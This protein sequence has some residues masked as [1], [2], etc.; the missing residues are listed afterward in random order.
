M[1][2]ELVGGRVLAPFVGTSIFVWS[3]LIGVILAA[4]SAGY[5]WGGRWADKYPDYKNFSQVIFMAAALIA[6]TGIFK[7]PIMNYL[8]RMNTDISLESIFATLIL[9]A[10]ASFFLATISPYAARLRMEDIKQSGQIVGNLY[11]IS[12][13]GSILGTFLTGF[14]L[15]SYVGSTKIIFILAILMFLA[16]L[17][18]FFDNKNF[19]HFYWILFLLIFIFFLTSWWD[20]KYRPTGQIYIT[21][22][23]SDVMLTKGIDYFTLRPI[24]ALITDP[25]GIQSAMYLDKDTGPVAK[26]LELFRLV[27]YFKPDFKKTLMLGGAGYS[28]PKD[29]LKRYQ[30]ATI[31]VV[32]IDPKMTA[33]ARQYFNLKDDSRL[34]I[35]HEDGRVYLNTNDERYDA[36]F[37]DVFKNYLIPFQMTTL[38]AAQKEYNLLAENGA[39]FVNIISAIQGDRGKFLR[40]EYATY[41]QIF[42]QVYVFTDYYLFE[43]TRFQ[44]LTFVAFKSKEIPSFTSNNKEL[45]GYLEHLWKG[46]IKMDMP[47]LT[48]DYAPVDEYL[49]MAFE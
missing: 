41:K 30:S 23:Y 49:V 7:L 22:Q 46:E 21:T 4:L 34:K 48:D 40:A 6:L 39:V 35:I 12:T 44:N 9:F 20:A 32:E 5:W 1:V 43:G 47:V 13:I 18:A 2:F 16:S 27:E 28:F 19:K 29:Y 3:S 45:S 8:Q 11:A 36:I 10:P 25:K 31:D 14:V 38:E 42:P 37:V 24:L 26:Y 15:F 17:L 33:I